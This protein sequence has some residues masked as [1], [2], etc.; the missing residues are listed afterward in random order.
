MY[1]RRIPN[2]IQ[3]FERY[4]PKQV[5]ADERIIELPSTRNL[6][7]REKNQKAP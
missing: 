1:Y 6:Q 4:I 5:I 7:E 2:N 3:N